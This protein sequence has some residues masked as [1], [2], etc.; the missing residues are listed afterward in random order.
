MFFSRVLVALAMMVGVSAFV[1][2]S[3]A[4]LGRTALKYGKYDDQL[5][6]MDAKQ[7]VFNMW[8]PNSPRSDQNFNPFE[9]NADGN[10]CDCSG[11]FPGE[12]KYKDPQ[13]PDTN[14]EIMMKEKE[15]LANILANPKAGDVPG[16]PGRLTVV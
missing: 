4:F 8:D 1:P 5:W 16:A 9:Q 12:G 3:G 13:R 11:F 15:V 2:N 14:F 6:D 10:S 7:D